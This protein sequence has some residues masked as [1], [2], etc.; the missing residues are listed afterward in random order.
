MEKSHKIALLTVSYTVFKQGGWLMQNQDFIPV[1]FS[2]NQRDST[3][4]Q[5]PFFSQQVDQRLVGLPLI[6]RGRD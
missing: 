3:F 6:G 5:S 4:G 2:P 1:R